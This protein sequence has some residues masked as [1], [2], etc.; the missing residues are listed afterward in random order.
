MCDY[1]LANVPNRLAEESETLV[2][3]LFPSGTKGFASP[4]DFKLAE[5]LGGAFG[6]LLG[7]I[8]P[9]APCAVCVPP[10][11]RLLL[12]D[13]PERLQQQLGVGAQEEVT[14]TQLS[15]DAYRHRDAIRFANSRQV[16]LQALAQGQ[17]VDVLCLSSEEEMLEA[18]TEAAS[19]IG[20]KVWLDTSR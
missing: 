8:T 9:S 13:V 16:L 20:T 17:R 10:G 6:L 14:F 7:L 3:H 11:A 19:E 5:K 1:S 15:A 2:V 4:A 12:H 18:E